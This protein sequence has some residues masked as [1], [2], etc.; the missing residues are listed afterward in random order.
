MKQE[1]ALNGKG[2]KERLPV[3]LQK[4]VLTIEAEGDLI[5]DCNY[6]IYFADGWTLAGDEVMP[7]KNIK[8]AIHFIK[9]AVKK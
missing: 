7:V 3:Y 8:E 1:K 2:L 9:D 4:K 5:G 6:M